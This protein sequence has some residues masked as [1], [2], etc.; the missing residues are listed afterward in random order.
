[1]RTAPT[2]AR[3]KASWLI[4][5]TSVHA[6]RLLTDAVAP[7]GGHGHHFLVLAALDEFGAASQMEI[8]Q[9]IGIDRSDTHAI[10]NDLVEQGFAERAP[11]PE[12]RRRNIITI[13]DAGRGRLAE[14]DRILERVQDKLLG[15][16]SPGERRQFVALLTRVLD[17][18]E[19][20]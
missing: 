10:V 7:V 9:R 12:D 6:H 1:M 20:R 18:Q 13:T 3:S 5:K 11:D 8:G 17:G 15:A 19:D 16:L 4:N 2:R 14:L